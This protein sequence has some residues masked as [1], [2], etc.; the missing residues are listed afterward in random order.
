MPRSGH[1]FARQ[2]GGGPPPEFPL[3]SSCP[4]I[5]HHLS[6]PNICA[7]TRPPHPRRQAGP[8]CPL[9]PHPCGQAGP[10]SHRPR[11]LRVRVCHPNTRT[12]V[13][14]LGPCFKTGR[15][16]SFRQDRMSRSVR[17]SRASPTAAPLL[18]VAPLSR[19]HVRST[20]AHTLP[21]PP[22]PI[23]HRDEHP[24]A[25]PLPHHRMMMMTARL[26][27]PLVP[28]GLVGRA[29][30]ALTRMPLQQP[31]GPHTAHTLVHT[32][33]SALGR[34]PLPASNA[35]ANRFPFNNF[36]RYLTPFSGCFS[37]F[38]HGTFS[39]SVSCP[40]LALDGVYHPFGL[41]SQTTRLFER[42]PLLPCASVPRDSYPLW[43]PVPG[44]LPDTPVEQFRA[45]LSRLQ[46]G[47]SPTPCTNAPAM[48]GC[49]RFQI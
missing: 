20:P 43:W 40:Y 16:A 27:P 1:R 23:S 18:A 34:P 30:T 13:G 8:W 10:C 4:G 12:H 11:W 25:C 39:L 26:R 47:P 29:G 9:P 15:L 17:A 46:F 45:H 28:L 48:A 6:G 32:P 21:P 5:V 37:S 38:P 14:L 3:A 41:H 19:M 24:V 22:R 35:A 33:V 49:A 31:P 7:L 42:V 36:T 2:N 44:H